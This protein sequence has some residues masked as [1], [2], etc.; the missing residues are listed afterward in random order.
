MFEI[1][2][3][4]LFK[5]LIF[6]E[7]AY[8][9]FVDLAILTVIVMTKLRYLSWRKLDLLFKLNINIEVFL[10][11]RHVW[12][13]Q[14]L[15]ISNRNLARRWVYELD[16]SILFFLLF[17]IEFLDNLFQI[18]SRY[19]YLEVRWL[20]FIWAVTFFISIQFIIHFK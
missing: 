18:L 19:A 5:I 12:L 16:A 3:C 20:L 14:L 17:F 4:K 2:L 8:K 1:F 15:I 6:F 7:S 13:I 11:Q 9:L 10:F